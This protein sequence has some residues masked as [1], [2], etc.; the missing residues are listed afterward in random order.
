[1]TLRAIKRL[2]NYPDRSLAWDELIHHVSNQL[3]CSPGEAVALIERFDYFDFNDIDTG[4]DVADYCDRL[5]KS[6]E[7]YRIRKIGHW[8]KE[9]LLL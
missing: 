2:N 9:Y 3:N 8:I 6:A 4:G 1:M 5:G 7:P